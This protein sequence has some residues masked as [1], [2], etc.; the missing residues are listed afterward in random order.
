MGFD[1]L[2]LE[3]FLS[4]SETGSFTQA[5]TKVGRTQS[6][7]SQ[8]VAKL[9][10]EIGKSLFHRGKGK[11]FTLTPDGEIFITYA[12]EIIRLQR[13]ALDRFH[14]PELEGEVRFGIPEDF[15]SVFLSDV[16]T[17]FTSL[18]PLVLLNIE[19]DLTLNLFEQF[20]KKDFD[21]VLVKMNKP[22]DF[23]NGIEVWSETL[24]WVGNSNFF[25][26]PISEPIPLVLSPQPCVYRK[27]AIS[28]L[29]K[30]NRKWRIVFS[31][32]SYA[33]TIAAVKA[34]MGV[35]VL[36]RNMIPGDTEI[37]HHKKD[38]PRLDDTHI[39]L[40]KHERDN[41]AINS[42]ERFVIERLKA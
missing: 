17:E 21:L 36:P 20:K 31:S 32:H 30:E 35:T 12:R 25:S 9:E 40:L 8:Q 18:H 26:N 11:N 24:E 4:V 41:T 13:E 6:A 28:A 3:C 23:P 5:A 16:L 27:R 33:S 14:Q 34:G 39:S 38:I 37:I 22:E 1:S 10:T 2:T 15:A 19:C 29:E 7:V 42:F